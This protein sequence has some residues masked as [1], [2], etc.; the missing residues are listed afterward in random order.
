MERRNDLPP[1]QTIRPIDAPP[2]SSSPTT[3]QLRA[4]IDSGR[5]GDKIA[6]FDPGLSPLGTDDE[7]AGTPAVPHRISLARRLEGVQRWAK[8]AGRA[9]YANR[10]ADMRQ[11]HPGADRTWLSDQSRRERG[12][13]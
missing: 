1:T 8:G 12:P 2:A 4:D 9:A 13:R 10:Q 5:T 3:A 7:A 11:V 6:V